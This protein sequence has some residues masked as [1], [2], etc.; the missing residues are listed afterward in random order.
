MI[1]AALSIF[2]PGHLLALLA[3]AA[4]AAGLTLAFRALRD[5]SRAGLRG[6]LALA[7]AASLVASELAGDVIQLVRGDWSARLSLPLHMCGL[8]IATCAVALW[9]VARQRGPSPRRLPGAPQTAFELSYFWGLGGTTQALLTPEIHDGFPSPAFVQFF[10]AHGGVVATVLAMLLGI[11]LRPQP[12]FV[13]R[14]GLISNLV[15][16][17]LGGLNLL[18]GWNYWYL[19]GPPARSSLYDFLGAWPWPILWFEVIGWTLLLLMYLPFWRP[20][21]AKGVGQP[22][23]APSERSNGACDA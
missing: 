8:S 6:R 17:A 14:V 9:G 5:A 20:A 21:P 12:G 13:L 23:P 7:L 1:A 19:C 10:L 3:V 11:G 4:A 18:T 15:M 2:G 16:A 22:A